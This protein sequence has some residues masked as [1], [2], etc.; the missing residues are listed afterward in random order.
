MSLISWFLSETTKLT[1]LSAAWL[2][3][4]TASVSGADH[5]TQS[6]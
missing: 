3:A 6:S 2:A 4:H 5:H 1:R